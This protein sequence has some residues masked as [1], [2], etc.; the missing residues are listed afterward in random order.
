MTIKELP[1]DIDEKILDDLTF[2]NYCL[3]MPDTKND[4]TFNDILKDNTKIPRFAWAKFQSQLKGVY[5]ISGVIK[6]FVGCAAHGARVFAT[7]GIYKDVSLLDINS[8]Y[9]EMLAKMEI[10]TGTPEVWNEKTDLKKCNY[11]ILE[12]DITETHTCELYPYAET[13]RRIMDRYDIEDQVKYCNM[14]YNI[15]RGYIWKNGS[16]SVKHFVTE[17]YD[18]KKNATG[19]TRN[20]YKLML[21]SIFG[22]TLQKN[23]AQKR[24]EY[25]TEE[26]FNDALWKYEKRL[27]RIDYEK[28]EIILEK[29]YD[30]NFNFG[31]IG[32]AVLSLAKRKIN[33]IF[34]FCINNRINILY[35]NCDSILIH[36]RDLHYFENNI[37]GELGG[38]HVEAQ[39]S[40]AVVVGRG[41]YYL[42]DEHFRSAG[43]SHKK[44]IESGCIRQFFVNKL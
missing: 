36:T 12:L 40:E 5:G 4:T 44:I 30:N 39:S 24:K 7:P 28:R 32:C 18:K 21:N 19:E 41:F 34:D 25:T 1:P 35:H 14:K 2:S 23:R 8:L 26:K 9:P 20:I 6:Y 10:P 31:F 16:M 33:G 3:R 27:T 29:C 37:N 17:L 43:T 15:I 11:Y 22:K 38:W 13:G 42:S